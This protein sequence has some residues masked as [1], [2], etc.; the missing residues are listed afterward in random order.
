MAI[1]LQNKCF[2]IWYLEYVLLII[3]KWEFRTFTHNL[4]FFTS[5]YWYLNNETPRQWTKSRNCWKDYT[6]RSYTWTYSI[7][8]M[9]AL[10]MLN[11][12]LWDKKLPGKE[13][14]W[15]V[16]Y[17]P[18]YNYNTFSHWLPWCWAMHPGLQFIPTVF[19]YLPLPRLPAP[20][21]N[22]S[23]RRGVFVGKA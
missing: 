10:C 7:C 17:S 11:S 22:R 14:P 6:H 16:L 4:V 9:D 5:C 18:K 3:R 21:H 15:W 23:K 8:M 13:F 19:S 20:P 1:F 2:Y 12:V